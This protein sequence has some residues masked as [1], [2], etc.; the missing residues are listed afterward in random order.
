MTALAGT[1]SG[2]IHISW[3]AT[4]VPSICGYEAQ[5]FRF[6]DQSV[7][8]SQGQFTYRATPQRPSEVTCVTSYSTIPE[9]SVVY[10]K[11][12]RNITS[13][14]FVPPVDPYSKVNFYRN[15]IP[16]D[17][18]ITPNNL[19]LNVIY[20]S[21]SPNDKIITANVSY[22]RCTCGD[23]T[24]VGQ[25]YDLNETALLAS[26][27]LSN[28]DNTSLV[29][30]A[31]GRYIMYVTGT[32]SDAPSGRYGGYGQTIR[33]ETVLAAEQEP[34]K[35]KEE[36]SNSRRW[37]ILVLAIVGGLIVVGAAVAFILV[38]RRQRQNYYPL[39]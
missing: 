8:V 36:P 31:Y 1:D 26:F 4:G 29:D 10:I 38:R 21:S 34:P 3:N 23:Y 2:K 35:E 33:S 18:S 7:E 32:C 30:I 16:V 11:D 13:R 17:A 20:E 28:K 27:S 24:L 22:D 19:Q 12:G 25:I 6:S 37:I 39:Q 9:V 5:Q 15:L 14:P